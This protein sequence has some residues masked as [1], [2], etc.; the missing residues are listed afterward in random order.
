LSGQPDRLHRQAHACRSPTPRRTKAANRV[1]QRASWRTGCVSSRVG[2]LSGHRIGSTGKLTHAV[3]QLH[4]APSSSAQRKRRNRPLR[5]LGA[6]RALANRVRQLPGGSLERQLGSAP[7]AS[8]RMP[9]ANSTANRKRKR[10]VRQRATWRTGCVSSRVGALSG[11]ADRLHRQAHAC[12]SPAHGAPMPAA[13]R[14]R[15]RAIGEPGASAPGWEPRAFTPIGSTGKLTHAVRQ[16]HG[17]PCRKR[18]TG[19]VSAQLANRVRQL[20][21]GSLEWSRRIG[22]TGKLT[23]AVRPPGEPRPAIRPPVVSPPANFLPRETPR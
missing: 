2:A 10:R 4:G 16:L 1:R 20:P 13:N 5:Q 12:R 3:R 14:V 17:A 15:Q 6:Q 18:R 7:P 23:H 11:H 21:G 9:F 19:C 8:S 22:S